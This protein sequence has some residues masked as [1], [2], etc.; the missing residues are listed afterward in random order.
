MHKPLCPVDPHLENWRARRFHLTR[1]RHPQTAARDLHTVHSRDIRIGRIRV[2]NRLAEQYVRNLPL[3][4][5]P[6]AEQPI[7]PAPISIRHPQRHQSLCHR[8]PPKI[9]DLPQYQPHTPQVRPLL[10]KRSPMPLQQPKQI[11]QQRRSWAILNHG[12]LLFEFDLATMTLL[13]RLPR[14]STTQTKRPK[15][16]DVV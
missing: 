5:P 2:L 15:S 7:S 6:S 9:E 11:L 10:P 8:V 12:S 16:R 14:F 13:R 3:F 4:I 1:P